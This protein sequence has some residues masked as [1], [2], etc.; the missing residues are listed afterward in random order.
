MCWKPRHPIILIVLSRYYT[1]HLHSSLPSHSLQVY[2]I[3]DYIDC[4]CFFFKPLV[5]YSTYVCYPLQP[6]TDHN[7]HILSQDTA[8]STTSLP[9]NCSQIR[10]LLGHSNWV[11]FRN[12]SH[13]FYL[14]MLPL[15]K[16]PLHILFLSK[17]YTFHLHKSFA[18]NHP[19]V[20]L[21]FNHNL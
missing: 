17:P 19:Q 10:P 13:I 12:P 15:S 14:R 4:G 2:L 16:Y 6:S 1:S 11:F 8:S 21:I 7:G 3:F 18:S 9:S 20:D 5:T